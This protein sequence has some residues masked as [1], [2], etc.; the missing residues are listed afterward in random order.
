MGFCFVFCFFNMENSLWTITNT[1]V[2]TLVTQDLSK[3][4]HQSW[5]LSFFIFPYDLTY[6]PTCYYYRQTSRRNLHID[7]GSAVMVLLPDINSKFC[8]RQ[9]KQYDQWTP[10]TWSPVFMFW[11]ITLAPGNVTLGKSLHLKFFHQENVGCWEFNKIK[12]TNPST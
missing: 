7:F 3:G 9:E 2:A 6:R 10:E 8:S 1:S 5:R 4:Y 12:H 11:L